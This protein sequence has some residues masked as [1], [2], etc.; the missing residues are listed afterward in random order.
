[1]MRMYEVAA[2]VGR[3]RIDKGKKDPYLAIKVKNLKGI[4]K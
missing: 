4:N 3:K 1:M 2:N